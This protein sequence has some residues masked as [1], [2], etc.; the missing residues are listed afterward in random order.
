VPMSKSAVS[1]VGEENAERL[2]VETLRQLESPSV[3]LVRI[4]E[5][6]RTLEPRLPKI[7]VHRVLTKA[8]DAGSIELRPD[9]GTEF[10][11]AED[12]LLCIPGPR[13]TVFSYA[14]RRSS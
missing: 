7:D 5:L 4:A 6:V 13:G 12:A 11:N 2:V 9:G 14:R 8:F 3:K 1:N 10:L